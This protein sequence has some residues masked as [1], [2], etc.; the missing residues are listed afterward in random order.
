MYD[1]RELEAE[2]GT[3]G[4][5]EDQDARFPVP[6]QHFNDGVSL[7][8]SS[9]CDANGESALFSASTGA[10]Q[11]SFITPVQM[12]VIVNA[13]ATLPDA[14]QLD[15]SWGFARSHFE[16]GFTTDIAYRF[17]IGPIGNF[18]DPVVQLADNSGA[19]EVLLYNYSG[20]GPLGYDQ[21]LPPGSYV[22]RVVARAEEDG[23]TSNIYALLDFWEVPPTAGAGSVSMLTLDKAG[24]GDLS[25]AWQPS[26]SSDDDDYG[27]YAGDLGTFTSHT[28]VQCGTL[29]ATSATITPASGNRYY[30]LVPLDGTEEGSYGTDSDGFDRTVGASVC[31][32][33]QIASPCP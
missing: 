31:G 2:V 14:C 12:S 1:A 21:V 19:S 5:P 13:T 29:G 6:M 11:D 8:S 18:E 9:F 30:L 32:T 25:L 17:I 20:S 22:F 27:I 10:G 33:Q 28:S 15:T 26:C 24:G 23:E 7:Q 3:L 16:I 4:G